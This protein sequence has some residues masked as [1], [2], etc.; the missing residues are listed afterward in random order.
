MISKFHKRAERIGRHRGI[1]QQARRIAKPIESS[2]IRIQEHMAGGSRKASD[3]VGINLQ[4]FRV[5]K[6]TV[7]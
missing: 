3:R 7:S 4:N 5:L 1:F 6:L 2:L